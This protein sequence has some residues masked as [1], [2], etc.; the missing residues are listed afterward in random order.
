MNSAQ[1]TQDETISMTKRKKLS[2]V[3]QKRGH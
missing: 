3:R 1:D 2:S